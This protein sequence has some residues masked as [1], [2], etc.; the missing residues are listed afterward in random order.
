M[1]LRLLQGAVFFRLKKETLSLNKGV[2][3]LSLFT[4]YFPTF[5]PGIEWKVISS[6]TAFNQVPNI[7]LAEFIPPFQGKTYTFR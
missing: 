4:P 3:S 5:A 1:P 2:I 6:H 7:T